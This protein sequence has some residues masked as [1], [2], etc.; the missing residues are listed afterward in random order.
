VQILEQRAAAR[1]ALVIIGRGQRERRDR[2][3][4][5]VGVR[6]SVR[7]NLP[8]LRSMSCTISASN[9]SNRSSPG[10]GV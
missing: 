7:P 6:P 1:D 8:S 2:A 3:R 4:D 5:A 9:I 10:R